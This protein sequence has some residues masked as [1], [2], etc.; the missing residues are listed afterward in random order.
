M[1]G[2][3]PRPGRQTASKGREP[4]PELVP[5]LLFFGNNR[6]PSGHSR[7]G[8]EKGRVWAAGGGQ[9]VCGNRQLFQ[10][11]HL[12][13][14]LSP[15]PNKLRAAGSLW[16]NAERS[17]DRKPGSRRNEFQPRRE[18]EAR[19]GLLSR[20]VSL[21]QAL[22]VSPRRTFPCACARVCV[23]VCVCVYK[24]RPSLSFPRPALGPPLLQAQRPELVPLGAAG[25]G[26]GAAR[27]GLSRWVSETVSG[28]G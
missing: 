19:R 21:W 9:A 1:D 18:G 16:V 6:L 28:K 10:E 27:S 23:C 11:Q 5:S 3:P 4:R 7:G 15:V 8:L 13:L 12:F 20:T 2:P 17:R 24:P 26:A 25:A 22:V 14:V